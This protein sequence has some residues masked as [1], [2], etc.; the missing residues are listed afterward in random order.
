M[1]ISANIYAKVPIE[2]CPSLLFS[3]KMKLQILLFVLGLAGTTVG[4]PILGDEIEADYA[5]EDIQ[6]HAEMLYKKYCTDQEVSD[7]RYDGV[8]L[9]VKSNVEQGPFKVWNAG[10]VTLPEISSPP[11][12]T[13]F[14]N[15]PKTNVR[16]K[17]T[18]KGDRA[19]APKTTIYVRPGFRKHEYVVEED[20]T[21]RSPDEGARPTLFFLEHDKS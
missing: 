13:I 19:P 4:H 9:C 1:S 16:H 2:A 7:Y 15:Q 3:S 6:L 8:V 12:L 10:E 14:V 17:V 11:P 21:K 20:L 5:S 18:V